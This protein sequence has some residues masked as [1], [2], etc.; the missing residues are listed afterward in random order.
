MTS[1]KHEWRKQ[2]KALYL[3]KNKPEIIHVPAFQFVTITGEGNPNSEGFA[4]YITA[5]YSVSYAIKMTLK[6]LSSPP[7]GYVDYTVYPLEG[8][9]DLNEEAKKHFNGTLNKD[10]FVFHLMI[11][12]PDFVEDSFFQE[13]IA[14]TKKKKPHP[15]L[16]QLVFET[17]EEKRCV[18]ILHLGS[19]DDEPASFQRMEEFA[20][21]EGVKR[22]SK[23][24]REIYLSDFRK[25]PPEK[26]KTVLRFQIA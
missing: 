24:H 5:L 19:Y 6:K 14:L 8:V 2:E 10:D 16:D 25:V 18:Q 20:E 22:L 1:T 3:P 7:P 26:L 23:V 15:L 11:R 12:Q 13:M 4:D 9:W 21:K 17:I